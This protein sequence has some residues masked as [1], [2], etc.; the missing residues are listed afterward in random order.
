MRNYN[1]YASQFLP[2]FLL[3]TKEELSMIEQTKEIT[4]RLLQQVPGP[5][6]HHDLNTHIRALPPHLRNRSCIEHPRD[7]PHPNAH[8]L[9]LHTQTGRTEEQIKTSVLTTS[10]LMALSHAQERGHLFGT[11]LREKA[12]TTQCVVTNG[13]QLCLGVFQ[14]NTMHL[15]DDKGLW[16]RAWFSPVWRLPHVDAHTQEVVAGE[17]GAV[18]EACRSII[19][20][21][22]KK[23]GALML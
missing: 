3:K 14:L 5:F 20:L 19:G 15:N 2:S 23:P 12:I 22:H 21:L 16:N 18:E 6:R 7:T 10:F 13:A 9:F 11:E 8:T 4:P 1:F 17:D